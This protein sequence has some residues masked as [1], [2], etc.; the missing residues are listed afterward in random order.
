MT[1]PAIPTETI[2]AAHAAICEQ[3]IDECL[4]PDWRGKCV[5]AVEAAASILGKPRTITTVGE[6]NAL[7]VGS[8]VMDRSGMPLHLTA[9]CGGAASNVSSGI[10]PTELE[11]DCVPAPVLHVGDET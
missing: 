7:P 9:F 10:A 3:N 6:M 2:T 8:V 1:N 5:K 11:R 4:D